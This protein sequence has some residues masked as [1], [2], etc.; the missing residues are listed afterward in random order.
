MGELEQLKAGL[1]ELGVAN[2][3]KTNPEMLKKYFT[4]INSHEVTADVHNV[5]YCLNH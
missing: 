4:Y 5:I 1:N 2:Q 3:L